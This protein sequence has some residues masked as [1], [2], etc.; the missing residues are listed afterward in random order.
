MTTAA[1][2]EKTWKPPFQSHSEL[3]RLVE[4]FEDCSLPRSKWNHEAHLAV[5]IWYLYHLD[6]AEASDRMIRGIRRYNR[7]SRVNGAPRGV[8]Y[9]ETITLFWLA[10]GR[11]YLASSRAETGLTRCALGFISLYSRRKDLVFRH[12]SR[13]R[14]FSPMARRTWVEPDLMPLF[15]SDLSEGPTHPPD[16]CASRP[17]GKCDGETHT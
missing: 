11:R 16:S 13:E 8:G 10:L 1:Q 17:A 6:E 5:A 2:T 15:G 3:K 4:Q 14:L 9:H 7:A 12:Y